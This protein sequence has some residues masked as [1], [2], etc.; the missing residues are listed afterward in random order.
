MDT[1]YRHDE[2]TPAMKQL[3][4]VFIILL[5]LLYGT[6][7]EVAAQSQDT[8]D[9][10]G[11]FV[12][13]TNIG[14]S[15]QDSDVRAIPGLGMGLTLEDYL[16]G[17]FR[18]TVGLSLRGRYL[19]TMTNGRDATRSYG[20][21][22]N[23]QLNGAAAGPDY[24]GLGYVYQNHKTS[25]HD[26]GMEAKLN[27]NIGRTKW[28]HFH[29]FGGLGA[30]AFR[31]RMDQSDVFGSEYNYANINPNMAE[32]ELLDALNTMRNSRF[33]TRAEG[34]TGSFNWVFTPA[35]GTGL[36]INVSPGVTLYWEHRIGFPFTDLL[37]GQQWNN[38]NT[39]T[40]SNDIHHYSTLGID[41]LLNGGGKSRQTSGSSQQRRQPSPDEQSAS[42]KLPNIN[43]INQSCELIDDYTGEVTV[44]SLIHRVPS[45]N[46]IQVTVNGNR[47]HPDDYSFN[48]ETKR[49]LLK[50]VTGLNKLN[51]TIL[52]SNADG[53]DTEKI[54]PACSIT[55][56]PEPQEEDPRQDSTNES[57]EERRA[58][59]PII[60]V[61]NSSED[62]LTAPC[63]THFKLRISGINDIS[64]LQVLENG[65]PLFHDEYAVDLP[66]VTLHR[67]IEEHTTFT[68]IATNKAGSTTKKIEVNCTEA[69]ETNA[70]P[71][72]SSP[73]DQDDVIHSCFP[74]VN[75]IIDHI[76]DNEL[77]VYLDGKALSRHDYTFY[78]ET[79]EFHFYTEV[80]P[81]NHILS[82]HAANAAG[83]AHERINIQCPKEQK[84]VIVTEEPQVSDECDATI[85][86][87]TRNI[88]SKEQLTVYQN[89]EPL[90]NFSFDPEKQ[91]L[92][93]NTSAEDGATIAIEAENSG[94]KTTTSVHFDC[95][96]EITPPSISI[97]NPR[98]DHLNTRN[99]EY[100]NIG[101]KVYNATENN[102]S[103]YVNDT[104]AKE[105]TYAF[106]ASTNTLAGNIHLSGNENTITIEAKNE[107]GKTTESIT[108][109]C[110]RLPSPQI[111]M[112]SPEDEYTETEHCKANIEAKIKHIP[113]K[114][115]IT[116]KQDG[117]ALAENKYRY[118]AGQGVLTFSAVYEKTA[119]IDIIANNP[120]NPAI[121]KTIRL[122]CAPE[123]EIPQPEIILLSPATTH[124]TVRSINCK[125]DIRFIVNHLESIKGLSVSQDGKTLTS[126]SIDEK[127]NKIFLTV[128]IEKT[129]NLVIKA[130]NNA[131][132]VS[133]TIHLVCKPPQ[134]KPVIIVNTPH[135]P[136]TNTKDCLANLKASV[137]NAKREDITVFV[138]DK[139]LSSTAYTI[140]R[141]GTEVLIENKEIN[142]AEE[143]I[144]IE[145]HN[146]TGSAS[147]ARTFICLQQPIITI[148][149]PDETPRE[150]ED[151]EVYIRAD[152]EN[153]SGKNNIHVTKDGKPASF[154]FENGSLTLSD[155]IDKK[156][157]YT[158]TAKNKA[159]ES[160]AEQSFYCLPQM[161]LPEVQITSH[162][163]EVYE[164][165]TCTTS[166]SATTK[167]INSAGDISVT[168]NN[169]PVSFHWNNGKL[170]VPEVIFSGDQ[171]LTITAENNTGSATDELELLCKSPSV[172]TPVI[173]ISTPEN[174]STTADDCT[175]KLK[176]S[177]KDV[178]G[179]EDISIEVNGE[180]TDFEWKNPHISLV[181]PMSDTR[182]KVVISAVNGDKKE[183]KTR[184]FVCKKQEDDVP[185]ITICMP[186]KREVDD[187]Q[188]IT[189]PES[190]WP[191][192]EKKG[193][194]KG[195]CVKGD[196]P[197]IMLL[198][199]IRKEMNV[200]DCEMPV[201]I[202][203]DHISGSGDININVNGKSTPFEFSRNFARIEKVDLEGKTIITAE[204]TNDVGSASQQYVLKCTPTQIEICHYPEEN[205]DAPETISIDE[206]DWP[207]YK[208]N[209][210]TKGSC[211]ALPAPE[212]NVL[213]PDNELVDCDSIP[214]KARV[215][216][217]SAKQNIEVTLNGE[218]IDFDWQEGLITTNTSG[219]REM[220]WNVTAS[221]GTG[222]T[223]ITH[224]VTCNPD[225][226][227]LTIC[228]FPPGNRDNPQTITISENAWPAH[229][230]HGDTQGAC[231]APVTEPSIDFLK[232]ASS[233]TS[234][235]E[236]TQQIKAR[237]EGVESKEQI[238]LSANGQPLRF[239]WSGN[240][241]MTTV[242]DFTEVTISLSVTNSSGTA[243][244]ERKITCN[245]P[246]RKMTICHYPPGNRTNPQTITISE[247]AWPAH[248]RHGDTQGKCPVNM[249]DIPGGIPGLEKED[250]RPKK[251]KEENNTKRPQLTVVSPQNEQIKSRDC[252]GEV[253]V[254]I[255]HIERKSDISV[256]VDGRKTNFDWR[257]NRITIPVKITRS[258]I[259][260]DIKAKNKGGATTKSVKI[261]CKR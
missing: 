143:T 47:L 50:Q 23:P 232:P 53:S 94:G 81:G 198:E 252:S 12:L 203:V 36:G 15:W 137:R 239:D 98:G 9:E 17:N 68:I 193:A 14:F 225:G 4:F 45:K 40:E 236:C 109:S 58:N 246:D 33:E 162:D 209:G 82:L 175:I 243:T 78:P 245:K 171:L 18:S 190:Q 212:I 60:T 48:P 31:T 156:G 182:A 135:D 164:S 8:A 255:Q 205:P 197:E 20:I 233:Q 207:E 161:Q 235:E 107:G 22:N 179:K 227:K 183:T 34:S 113:E 28:L 6:T 83:R 76:N 208:R 32:N 257:G 92:K 42:K 19:W 96:E 74:D 216:Q 63:K 180:A 59:P 204:A 215:D 151:C 261:S 253:I 224:N 221:N 130:Q 127:K 67:T 189:I 106:D 230:K 128:D 104:L 99:C 153:V 177:I 146:S 150:S 51:I 1:K 61:V 38:N 105:N 145:A 133:Q 170:S 238:Q 112:V 56:L 188:T 163:N 219:K 16:L 134:H 139:K 258:A 46:F 211:P 136:V 152:I 260:V 158:I 35:L 149:K 154:H 84:P 85:R 24:S 217:V 196:A 254:S 120:D 65:H 77:D 54:T 87:I 62:S 256:S 5:T 148:T 27:F 103:V 144:T 248:E 75:Y 26:L 206:K 91:L 138:N 259:T 90:S 119:R 124:D 72:I 185:K 49:F 79:G 126:Y 237:I 7:F 229:Q 172:K 66:N 142:H 240:M 123:E 121:T 194:T 70:P 110:I 2:N 168:L 155:V 174:P 29:L 249:P 125:K 69:P 251:R 118:D 191:E 89:G 21:G 242:R 231:P 141:E 41:I 218:N 186:P 43:I 187:P 147:R 122:S 167:E 95:E 108:V 44:N 86:A 30:T 102:I 10:S 222:T 52:A 64:E 228:H 25:A 71:V 131:G 181:K 201:R 200:V 220:T 97:H 157:T 117:R 173:L 166:V 111:S 250:P 132:S 129:S 169:K 165:T 159:G 247:N 214:F 13:G 192:Y 100:L 3:Y 160:S 115:M 114:S 199:P 202:R 178:R 223:D 73:D 234:V 37:D 210:D 213:A 55:T 184:T 39:L 241:L 11:T 226:G 80:T 140:N 176:A 195:E 244:S 57:N 101:A 88:S 93:I 116:I